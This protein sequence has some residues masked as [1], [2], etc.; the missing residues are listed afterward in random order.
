MA[1]LDILILTCVIF[2]VWAGVYKQLVYISENKSNRTNWFADILQN[3][4]CNFEEH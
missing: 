2:W 4:K 3:F 1:A